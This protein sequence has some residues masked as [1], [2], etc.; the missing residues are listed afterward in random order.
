MM[1]IVLLLALLSLVE[2]HCQQTFPYVS[3]MGQTLA[4]HSYVD[5]SQV[6]TGSAG[7][8]CHTDLQTC[9]SGTQGPHRGDWYFPNGDALQFSSSGEDIF[10]N[11]GNQIVELRRR[12]NANGPTGIYHCDIETVAAVNGNGIRETVYMGLYNSDEGKHM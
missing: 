2:V 7:V 11:R 8:L 4:D 12:N 3:F 9:C 6:G 5:I 1:K 10:Q